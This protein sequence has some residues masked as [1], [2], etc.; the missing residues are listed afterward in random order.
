MAKS[1]MTSSGDAADAAFAALYELFSSEKVDRYAHRSCPI[2]SPSEV[3]LAWEYAWEKT[4]GPDIKFRAWVDFL[5]R[6]GLIFW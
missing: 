2:D 4:F 5:R 6:E 1:E 3:D